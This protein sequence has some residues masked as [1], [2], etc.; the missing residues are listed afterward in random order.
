MKTVFAFVFALLMG[1]TA[2]IAQAQEVEFNSADL[3]RHIAMNQV[4]SLN[5]INWKVGDTASYNVTAMFGFVKGTLVKSVASE[6]GNAIWLKQ[7]MNL[8]G[9]KQL[10][11]MLMDRA[12]GKIL[13][14]KQNGQDA[15]IPDDKPEIISQ[16]YAEI[17]VPA[18]TFKCVHIV[19]KS[20][21]AS[22]I[23]LWANPAETVMEG[24]IKQIAASTMGDVTMEMTS[25]KKVN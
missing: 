18:G 17:K 9:Q 23:E 25:F 7:D 1:A 15:Q 11:E 16:D 14:L 6:E 8:A 20:K 5:L 10:I 13:K 19:A 2:P 22:K 4:G 3:A 21:S 12:D 24:S